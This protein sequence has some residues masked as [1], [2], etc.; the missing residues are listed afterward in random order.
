MKVHSRTVILTVINI[1][2]FLGF[3][4]VSVSSGANCIKESSY[5]TVSGNAN[6]F[7]EFKKI[8]CDG[9][10]VRLSYKGFSAAGDGGGL[11]SGVEAIL[12]FG[13]NSSP[14]KYF[15]PR[16]GDTWESKGASIVSPQHVYPIHS[17]ATVTSVNETVFVTAGTFTNCAKVEE[18]LSYLKGY[19]P[20]QAH[21]IKFER[22]FAPGI[23]PVKILITDYTGLSYAGELLSYSNITSDPGDYFP[24][25][26]NSTWTFSISENGGRT[27][28]WTLTDVQNK[29]EYGLVSPAEEDIVPAGSKYTIMWGAP[30]EV[31]RVRLKYSLDDGMTWTLLTDNETGPYYVWDVPPVNGNK[32]KSLVKLTGYDG[33]GGKVGG[34]NSDP[35]AIEV[36]RL[37]SPNGGEVFASGQPVTVT[38]TSNTTVNPVNQVQLSY[39]LD[40]GVT[41]K[42]FIDQPSSGS[43]PGGYEVTLPIVTKTKSKGKVRVILRDAAQKRVG[44]EVSDGAFTIQKP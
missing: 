35:F 5:L 33:S 39:S 10:P 8:S 22:W 17:L 14:L 40:N 27:A 4:N 43:N 2:L 29:V 41:W 36:V 16:L 18:T 19:N 20:G 44:S 25:G 15:P 1:L 6:G 28:T 9:S 26:L 30:P 21:P 3:L 12:P 24:L 32:T 11:Y 38:W 7:V 13:T 23:G 37:T 31:T 34:E 42:N